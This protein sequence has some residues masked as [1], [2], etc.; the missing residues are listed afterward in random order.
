MCQSKETPEGHVAYTM[1]IQRTT[2]FILHPPPGVNLPE[3]TSRPPEMTSQGDADLWIDS[4]PKIDVDPLN[5]DSEGSNE[6]SEEGK[7]GEAKE[8]TEEEEDDEEEENKGEEGEE[9][10]GET[11]GKEEGVGSENME[12]GSVQKRGQEV[13][14]GPG[15]EGTGDEEQEGSGQ[16]ED[17]EGEDDEDDEE[18]EDDED[19]DMDD[20][21]DE[22]EEEEDLEDPTPKRVRSG[23]KRQRRVQSLGDGKNIESIRDKREIKDRSRQ[24][25]QRRGARKRKTPMVSPMRNQ[26]NSSLVE[27]DEDEAQ[28]PSVDQTTK[29]EGVTQTLSDELTSQRPRPDTTDGTSRTKTKKSKRKKVSSRKSK[30]RKSV[31]VPRTPGEIPALRLNGIR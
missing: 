17:E 31:P 12:T 30:T 29:P 27:I 20:D 22:E 7:K 6:E 9:E 2:S 10:H 16:Y 14:E 23:S 5:K 4:D 24:R 11:G 19:D 8:E 25:N 21:E 26:D 15:E 28:S 1:G 3:V 13:E 18:D